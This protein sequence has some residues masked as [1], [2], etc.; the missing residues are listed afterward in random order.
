MNNELRYGR[1]TSSK[2]GA[3]TTTDKKGTGWGAP[4]LTYIEEKWMERKLKRSL[5]AEVTSRPLEWGKIVEGVAFGKLD[6][7]YEIVS[8]KT[9]VHPLHNFWSGSP[10]LIKHGENKSVCD[11][12]CPYTLKSFCTFVDAWDSGGI[13]GIR[14][15]HKDGD[16]YYWQLV[17]NAILTN[18]T[19]AELILY[20][21]FFEDLKQIQQ[22]ADNYSCSWLCFAHE[23]ELPFLIKDG[24]YK[25]INVFSF[26]IPQN[27]ID[28]LTSKV[29]KADSEIDLKLIDKQNILITPIE[30]GVIIQKL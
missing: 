28:L 1:F 18:C 27:D 4:A 20:M 26:E 14:K 24:Y 30:D 7:S 5:N 2:I 17:S 11:I 9:I 21:P 19:H 10:D 13:D 6:T 15:A 23:I 16:T 25:S 3:L 8:E 12:K 22:E 29:I